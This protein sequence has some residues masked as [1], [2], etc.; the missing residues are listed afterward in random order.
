MTYNSYRLYS[1]ATAGRAG[2]HSSFDLTFAFDLDRLHF[3]PACELAPA[4]SCTFGTHHNIIEWDNMNR[5]LSKKRTDDSGKRWK[6]N[7]KIAEPEKPAFVLSS[8][9]PSSD[10]FRTSLIM[11]NLSARF[12]MLR[13]QD[14]PNTKIGKASDDSVLQPKRQSRLH[15]F[16]FIAQ[17]HGLSDIAE[18]ASVQ[19]S[20]RPPWL[21][22]QHDSFV[23]E[24]SF[25][26]TDSMAN[27]SIMSRARPGEGNNLFGGRQKVY[28]IPSST[29]TKSLGLP[30]VAAGLGK[31]VYE[32]D[33]HKSAFQKHKQQEKEA[34]M[35]N[36]AIHEPDSQVELT[37]L[38]IA[39]SVD[40]NTPK[41][42]VVDQRAFSA[43]ARRMSGD[44]SATFDLSPMPTSTPATSTTSQQPATSAHGYF[45]PAKVSSS[46]PPPL[47]RSLT[48]R[49]LY[50]QGLDQHMYEQQA[51]NLT[52]L[53]SIQKQRTLTGSKSPPP[54]AL[55]SKKSSNLQERSLQPYTSRTTSP[56][57]LTTFGSVRKP[58][59]NASMSPIS[60][61]Q[62]PTFLPL[63]E[64]DELDT[65]STTVQPSDR[66]KATAMG[67]FNKPRQQFDEDQYLRRLQQ[68]QQPREQPSPFPFPSPKVSEESDR[69]A[70]STRFDSAR[71]TP[72]SVTSQRRRSK[73]SPA[74]SDLAKAFSVFQNAAA[75]NRAVHDDS[76]R[77][78]PVIPDTHGTFFGDISASDDDDTESMTSDYERRGYGAGTARFPPTLPSVSE[79]PAL[80]SQNSPF[81]EIQ[82]E[83]E[84]E[85]IA[86]ILPPQP[87]IVEP[88]PPANGNM[89]FTGTDALRGLVH[90]H[91]RNPSDQSSIAP[92]VMHRDAVGNHVRNPS[93]QSSIYPGTVGKEDSVPSLADHSLGVA[94]NTYGSSNRV[95]SGYTNSNPWDLDDFDSSYYY[96]DMGSKKH[97]ASNG[98][99]STDRSTSEPAKVDAD[100]AATGESDGTTW[101]DDLKPHHTRDT[102]TGTIQERE[103]FANELAAR[104]KAIQENLRSIVEAESRSTSPQPN[105]SGAFKAFNMLKPKSS[106]ESIARQDA[107]TKAMKMLGLAAGAGNGASTLARFEE[108]AR[109]GADRIPNFSAG[110]RPLISQRTPPTQR[111]RGDSV[112]SS[113][114][115]GTSVRPS[116]PVVGY[117]QPRSRSNS[118]ASS[119]RA[120]SQQGKYRDELDRQGMSPLLSGQLPVQQSPSQPSSTPSSFHSPPGES[121]ARFRS[122]SRSNTPTFLEQQALHTSQNTTGRLTPSG[123]FSAPP[124][125]SLK[126]F[127]PRPA[128]PGSAYST[129]TVPPI[130]AV[131]APNSYGSFAAAQLPTPPQSAPIRSGGHM[132]RKKTVHKSDIS[133]PTLI[134]STSNVDTVDLPPGASL[135]NGMEISPFTT[136][137]PRRTRTQKIFG[138]GRESPAEEYVNKRVLA[139]GGAQHRPSAPAVLQVRSPEQSSNMQGFQSP[140]PSFHRPQPRTMR[141]EESFN[142][143]TYPPIASP[144][145]RVVTEGG[146]F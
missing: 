41:L 112:S 131:S 9:L 36:T 33:M 21:V 92:S 118:T 37:G 132:L 55:Q 10:D 24:D 137:H 7:K 100:V 40:E 39:T 57:L 135:K 123:P 97:N 86:E 54:N 14:D 53:N 78:T 106:R 47:E 102:S 71:H 73:S 50:E 87:S 51:S 74:K 48:K 49:R 30:G 32:N 113:Q 114:G 46:N 134:S 101:Q 83:D 29:S 26:E 110:P 115:N 146:M 99:P 45:P 105:P 80:R 52:R 89:L 65:L 35:A 64:Y 143:S 91:L 16:G 81:P 96:G 128:L 68:L 82:E 31:V 27:G 59:S 13:D 3:T 67:T 70:P 72:E 56:Q 23:S 62:S 60:H 76:P 124:V 139:F 125:P 144:E 103:A 130:S 25:A 1:H 145:R 93:N 15:E 4:P 117:S 66:G 95:N 5:F 119:I 6:R 17:T 129:N 140:P 34:D 126:G 79:H 58:D 136:G 107:P 61:P 22:R 42:A 2:L 138:F 43:P 121:Q 127:G 11:P 75:Q 133:E 141:S 90:Q 94:R 63:N 12:S 88:Q 120:P 98:R 111:V 28:K 85:G 38:G 18:V 44:S 109:P 20:V 122:N 142:H 69:S 19:S 8:T 77:T 84:E 116:P 108:D 104:Q